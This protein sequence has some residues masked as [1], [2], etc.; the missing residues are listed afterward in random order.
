[1][2]AL[3]NLMARHDEEQKAPYKETASDGTSGIPEYG[4]PLLG[5]FPHHQNGKVNLTHTETNLPP[6]EGLSALPIKNII[7]QAL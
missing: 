1:M 4:N 6:P 5:F 3:D 7:P 2:C